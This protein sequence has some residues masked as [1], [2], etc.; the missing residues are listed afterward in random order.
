MGS[1]GT[2]AVINIL[3]D[4]VIRTD[5]SSGL[6]VVASL[7]EVY[8]ALMADEVDAF[9]AF[10]MIEHLCRTHGCDLVVMNHESLWS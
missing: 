4:P 9:P 3:T 10:E 6:R 5:K 2:Q 7:P 8:A 1:H